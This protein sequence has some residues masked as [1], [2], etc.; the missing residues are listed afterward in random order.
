M[1]DAGSP[2]GS[3]WW[4]SG[5]SCKAKSTVFVCLHFGS[6]STPITAESPDIHDMP[7]P[8]AMTQ[9]IGPDNMLEC[10]PSDHA[11]SEEK[12]YGAKLPPSALDST[13]DDER[14]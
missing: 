10:V 6:K 1:Q 13:S 8:F 14:Y 12:I 7:A 2:C 9:Q 4:H 3:R 5:M 11:I